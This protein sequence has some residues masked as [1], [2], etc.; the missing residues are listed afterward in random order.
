MREVTS[1]SIQEVI[2][3]IAEDMDIPAWSWVE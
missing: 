1:T 2:N 3:Q